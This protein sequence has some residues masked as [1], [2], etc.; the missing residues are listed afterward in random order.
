MQGIHSDGSDIA[1][2][3]LLAS[4]MQAAMLSHACYKGSEIANIETMQACPASE[5]RR[6][7][8]CILLYDY[9]TK[10]D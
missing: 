6:M 9:Y 7:Q 1:L 3:S 5:E 4:S 2:Q 8:R 10:Q